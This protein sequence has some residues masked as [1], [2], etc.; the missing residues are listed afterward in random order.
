MNNPF[1]GLSLA[2]IPSILLMIDNVAV[3]SLLFQE[4]GYRRTFHPFFLYQ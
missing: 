2:F 1:L 3:C 4:R